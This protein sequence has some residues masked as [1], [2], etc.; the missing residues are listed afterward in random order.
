MSPPI[1]GVTKNNDCRRRFVPLLHDRGCVRALPR[2]GP[3]IK[4][5]RGVIAR[6]AALFIVN[7]SPGPSETRWSRF[8]GLRL[9]REE[10]RRQPACMSF[11]ESLV[12]S[13]WKPQR[14]TAPRDAEGD[15]FRLTLESAVTSRVVQRH[16]RLEGV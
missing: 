6:P 14:H 2:S 3:T 10:S 15:M 8:A 7:D 11:P 12:Q 4:F 16:M 9:A 1:R 13:K 5:Q